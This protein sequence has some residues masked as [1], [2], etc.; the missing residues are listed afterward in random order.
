MAFLFFSISQLGGSSRCRSY[1]MKYCYS[2]LGTILSKGSM[3]QG[4]LSHPASRASFISFFERTGDGKRGSAQ[5][6]FTV[7]SR[8]SP[9]SWVSHSG[10]LLSN[11]FFECKHQLLREADG[12]NWAHGKT[13]RRN[14]G[15]VVSLWYAYGLGS[16]LYLSNAL[17][18]LTKNLAW[19]VQSLFSVQSICTVRK[20]SACRVKLPVRVQ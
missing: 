19:F 4:K 7:W 9:N 1:A 8:R 2:N 11:W 20:G 6:C 5:I 3:L 13:W 15:P 17:S 10:L 14:Y 16:K 12:R 18:M